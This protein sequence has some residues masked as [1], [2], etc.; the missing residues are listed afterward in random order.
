MDLATRKANMDNG[1]RQIQERLEVARRNVTELETLEQRQI[2]A[3]QLMAALME[4]EEPDADTIEP[5]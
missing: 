4:P 3:L 1:L 2:G 5:E